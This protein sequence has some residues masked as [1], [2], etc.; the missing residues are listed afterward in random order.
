MMIYGTQ[1]AKQKSKI[2][3]EGL[4]LGWIL[5]IDALDTMMPMN[6]T[7][8]TLAIITCSTMIQ[9][10]NGIRKTPLCVLP[11]EEGPGYYYKNN[12]YICT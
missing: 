11:P 10:T 2:A 4:G 3:P 8:S 6:L 9:I 12:L 5:I 1:S 7:T